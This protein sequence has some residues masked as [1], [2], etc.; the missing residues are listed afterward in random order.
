MIRWYE[1]DIQLEMDRVDLEEIKRNSTV[2][3]NLSHIYQMY[4]SKKARTAHRT[5]PLKALKTDCV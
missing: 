3:S 2:T 5:Q 1:L 4:L